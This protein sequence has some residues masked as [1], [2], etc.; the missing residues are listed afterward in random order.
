MNLS[1]ITDMLK[2]RDITLP[3]KVCI[4]KAMVF[5]IV[6]YGWGSWTIMKAE[7]PRTDAFELW[8]WRRL[9]RVPWTTRS[10]QSI[11]KKI[12]PEYSLEGLLLKLKPQY[13]GHLM[14]RAD[15]LEKTLTLGK[16]EHKRRKGWQRM[17]WVGSITD[18]MNVNLS[19]LWETVENTGAWHTTVHGVATRQTQLSN[20]TTGRRFLS[21]RYWWLGADGSRR[22]EEKQPSYWI[23]RRTGYGCRVKE[24]E[25]GWPH[26]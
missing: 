23:W 24:R 11:L 2:N 17:S 20:W 26:W 12:N 19:K 4:V 16:T 7:C 22:G 8:C 3:T 10:N 25:K 1:F 5:S 13:F 14:W 6:M 18:S 9:L 15:P 21:N